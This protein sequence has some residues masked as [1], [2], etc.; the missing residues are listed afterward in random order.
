MSVF[1][2]CRFS[3]GDVGEKNG[4]RYRIAYPALLPYADGSAR[5]V[6]W[7]LPL[8]SKKRKM[9]IISENGLTPVA[10]RAKTGTE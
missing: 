6:V 3:G 1:V 8:T 4:K 7:E 5:Y 10:V 9:K 2:E